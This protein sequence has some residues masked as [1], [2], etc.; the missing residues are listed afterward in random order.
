MLLFSNGLHNATY[1]CFDNIGNNNFNLF[2]CW[3]FF[4]LLCSYSTQNGTQM[5]KSATNGNAGFQD[6]PPA[7]KDIYKL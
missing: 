3:L 6:L 7:Y 1:N 2:F 5:E 4:E